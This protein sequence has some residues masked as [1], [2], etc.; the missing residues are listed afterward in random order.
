MGRFKPDEEDYLQGTAGRNLKE[1]P[2]GE[3]SIRP[4]GYNYVTVAASAPSYAA[5]MARVENIVPGELREDVGIA[6]EP[7]APIHGFVVNESGEP[8][9][10][11]EIYINRGLAIV[12]RNG[13]GTRE[14]T[15]TN[16]DGEF[17][18]GEYSGA[19][20]TII[21]YHDEYAPRLM[22]MPID[23]A[24]GAPIRFVLGQGRRLE[25]VVT[26]G[27]EPLED[28][29]SNVNVR[30]SDGSGFMMVSTGADGAYSH[31][32]LHPGEVMVMVAFSEGGGGF[33]ATS[34]ATSRFSKTRPRARI[35]I[36]TIPTIPPWKASCSSTA[37]LPAGSTS[38]PS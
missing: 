10:R 29:R 17:T 5:A 8:V 30:L 18:I 4:D 14:T 2:D 16:S 26:H 24:R 21:A 3:F 31:A 11:A 15:R 28:G 32:M 38:A 25:G 9:P 20:L 12:N 33:T 7:I 27:G 34:N 35:S 22:E 6:L 1:H 13:R 23:E 37:N 19:N 36:L